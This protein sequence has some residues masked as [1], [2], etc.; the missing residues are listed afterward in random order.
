MLPYRSSQEAPYMRPSG[1]AAEVVATDALV[2][3]LDSGRRRYVNL[4][5][6]AS[7]PPL[8]AVR[9]AVERFAPW[10]SSVHRGSGFKSQVSTHAYE[11]AREAV[12]R[13]V[14][15]DAERDTV[16]FVLNTP[17]GM[18]KDGRALQPTVPIVF[19]TIM[20]QHANLMQRQ[21]C[22]SAE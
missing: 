17:E 20:V 21:D 16:V 12:G 18:N 7:A 14:G 9:D 2:P 22:A 19:T 3:S 4:D 5:N 8:V 6:A 13:F 11:A 15:P 10:Y 1:W